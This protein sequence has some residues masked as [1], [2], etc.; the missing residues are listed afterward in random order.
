M[1]H[2]SF[3]TKELN[4]LHTFYKLTSGKASLFVEHSSYTVIHTQAIQSALQEHRIT[5]R[6]NEIKKNKIC[7]NKLEF[8]KLPSFLSELLDVYDD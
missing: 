1:L 2:C 3:R 7:G 8:T 6:Q 4:P 5:R